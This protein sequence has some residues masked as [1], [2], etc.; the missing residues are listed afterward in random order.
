M[1]RIDAR[2]ALIS[3][4]LFTSSSCSISRYYETA[5]LN[6]DLTALTTELDSNVGRMN[7]DFEEKKRWMESVQ[8]NGADLNR[9]PFR[10]MAE[11][12]QSMQ[13]TR[14]EALKRSQKI[15]TESIRVSF[16]VQNKSRLKSNDPEFEEVTSFVKRSEGL[17]DELN[18]Q[19]SQ[20]QKKSD[21]FVEWAKNH[22]IYT[23]EI[24]PFKNRLKAAIADI[25]KQCELAENRIQAQEEIAATGSLARRELLA[26]MKS[27]IQEIRAARDELTNF[28][29]SLEAI[30]PNRGQLVV[31]PH[32]PH[33]K[34]FSQ[35]T[36]VQNRARQA[37]S[38]FNAG[39]AKVSEIR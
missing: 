21:Q 18:Q 23:I 36:T 32:L 10:E 31:G 28:E 6:R 9:S 35:F 13:S 29:M 24:A 33:E 8:T 26:Q 2:Y 1:L 37:A 20:Y 14:N 4:I 25:S 12:F 34:L 7:A 30:D 5:D 16:A 38:R 27:E 19:F 17:S 15:R 3:L 39:A 22:S 11:V